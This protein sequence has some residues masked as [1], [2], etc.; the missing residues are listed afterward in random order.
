MRVQPTQKR[1]FDESRTRL[2][3]SSAECCNPKG[4]QNG[5]KSFELSNISRQQNFGAIK[6]TGLEPKTPLFNKVKNLCELYK[7]NLVPGET[8]FGK[9][10]HYVWTPQGSEKEN[11][12]M[13]VLNKLLVDEDHIKIDSCPDKE[14][15]INRKRMLESN[16]F[17]QFFM[18]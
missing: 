16:P 2:A 11:A 18:K 10:K 4:L 14:A 17:K 15:K 6:L 1:N 5:A 3:R 13:K 8:R 7:E 12:V 9:L